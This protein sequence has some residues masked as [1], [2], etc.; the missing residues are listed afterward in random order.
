VGV[1]TRILKL[2]TNSKRH[3]IPGTGQ[4]RVGYTDPPAPEFGP[5][6]LKICD[7]RVCILNEGPP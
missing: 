6:T 1:G 3:L 5:V 7:E 4:E 2:E